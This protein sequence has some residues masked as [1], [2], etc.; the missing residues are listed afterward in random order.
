MQ[1]QHGCHVCDPRKRPKFNEHR[2][3]R[4]LVGDKGLAF[5]QLLTAKR[6]RVVSNTP[7]TLW[8]RGVFE[9]DSERHKSINELYREDNTLW[10]PRSEIVGRGA[11]K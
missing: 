1:L 7:D 6:R 4:F 2:T 3:T 9:A 5:G 11:L 8:E 10:R